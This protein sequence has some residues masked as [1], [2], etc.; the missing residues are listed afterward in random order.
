[1]REVLPAEG[2][3]RQG[4][5]GVATT[6]VPPAGSRGVEGWLLQVEVGGTAERTK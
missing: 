4:A 2:G 1:M 3:W 6:E 5:G